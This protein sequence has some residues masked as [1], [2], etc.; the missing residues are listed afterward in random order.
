MS[1]N[2]NV[3]IIPSGNVTEGI[4]RAIGDTASLINQVEP[5]LTEAKNLEVEWPSKESYAQAGELLSKIRS[6]KKEGEAHWAPFN[7]KVERVRT[8]LKM[9][10]TALTNRTQEGEAHLL[11]KMKDWEVAERSAAKKEE[12]QENK[13]REQQGRP[14]VSVKVDVPSTPGYRRTVT[15]KATVENED[16]LLANWAKATGKEKAYLRQFICANEQRLGREAREVKD[17]DAL[18]KRVPGVKFSEG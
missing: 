6:I 9:K 7:I 18:N 11:P 4:E 3:E 13:Q 14:P 1:S 16:K 10:L 2:P 5:L 15:Y 12:K 17:C 8:F